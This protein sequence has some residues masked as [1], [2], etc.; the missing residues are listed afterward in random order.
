MTDYLK[1]YINEQ[2][3][4]ID[5][6]VYFKAIDDLSK[7]LI[8]KQVYDDLKLYAATRRSDLLSIETINRV[9][10]RVDIFKSYKK[11]VDGGDNP[12]AAA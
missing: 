10:K 9:K 8:T 6:D 2:V 12:W 3:G 1:N 4:Y 11:Q 5:D 7:E